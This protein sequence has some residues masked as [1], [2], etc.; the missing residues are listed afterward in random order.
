MRRYTPG[1]WFGVVTDDGIA[2]LPGDIAPALVE[3]IFTE[4]TAGHG[5]SALLDALTAEFGSGLASLPPFAIVTLVGEE[6]RL[7]VRGPLTVTA[8]GDAEQGHLR[9]SGA[10]VTTWSETA[11]V[12]P[13]RITVETDAAAPL[14]TDSARSPH[15]A[16]AS[17]AMSLPIVSGIVLCSSIVITLRPGD[18]LAGPGVP[19]A[20]AQDSEPRNLVPNNL[21]LDNRVEASGR[22]A[23]DMPA[24]SLPTSLPTSLPVS[25][26]T[27]LPVSLP[28][29]LPTPTAIPLESRPA[30][31]PEQPE[32]ADSGNETLAVPEFTQGRDYDG[33]WGALDSVPARTTSGPISGP[34]DTD[35]D[36][37]T[38][39]LEQLRALG[40]AA[41]SA[42]VLLG[43]PAWNPAPVPRY[44]R[45]LVS[46]GTEV[47]LDRSAVIGRKPSAARF[48]ADRMP[49]LVTVPSPQQDI[50][51]SH[52]EVR[53]EGESVLA[54]DLGT[55]NGTRLLRSGADP[56][57]LHPQEPT[58]LVHGDVLDLGD[59]I[60]VTYREPA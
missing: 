54:V 36:G 53:C 30:A 17:P 51:R 40:L 14:T 21:E 13:A 47:L 18:G 8:D 39:S 50:S 35:H 2:V 4:L 26:P 31:E 27:S 19:T 60:T 24:V 5:L 6:A 43:V 12:A 46:G 1:T 10:R 32:V 25:L 48:T 37:E 11:S 20:S 34:I 56:V 28:V 29:S 23:S 59:A 15:P 33:L 57:R 16:S 3:R 58:M 22:A 45:L 9:V 41:P 42:S 49:H 52:L 38:L 44:G 55:T 7:A